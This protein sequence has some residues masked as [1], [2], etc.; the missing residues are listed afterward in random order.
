[1][2]Y[3]AEYKPRMGAA[4][5]FAFL[6]VFALVLFYGVYFVDSRFELESIRWLVYACAALSV[7]IGLVA[8]FRVIRSNGMQ[9]WI[10]RD[11]FIEYESPTPFLG[12]SFRA[13]ID[14]V[15][16]IWRDGDSDFASCRLKSNRHTY[17]I[18]VRSVAG[19]EFFELLHAYKGDAEHIVGGNGG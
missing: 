2:T 4:F 15:D 11:G 14:D 10:I 7:I 17:R 16:A 18:D 13:P 9:R 19:W 12:E 8:T 5:Q 1:M 3:E 6:C